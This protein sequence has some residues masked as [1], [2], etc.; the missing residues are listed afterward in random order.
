MNQQQGESKNTNNIMEA[1]LL[2]TQ[3]SLAACEAKLKKLDGQ[4]KRLVEVRAE[5]E[6]QLEE[7]EA[8]VEDVCHIRHTQ[9]RY[10]FFPTNHECVRVDG[11][12]CSALYFSQHKFNSNLSQTKFFSLNLPLTTPCTFTLLQTLT[13]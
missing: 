6:V 9:E 13:L 10:I 7:E 2:A 3:R 12:R 11:C 4:Y 8:R 5:L 1:K